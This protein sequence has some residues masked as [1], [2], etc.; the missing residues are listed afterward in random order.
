MTTES[1]SNIASRQSSHSNASTGEGAPIDPW[2]IWVTF[3]RCWV[4]AVPIGLVIGTIGAVMVLKSFQPEYTARYIVAAN[5][6]WVIYKG[7]NEAPR[8]LAASEKTWVIDHPGVIQAVMGDQTVCKAPSLADPTTRETN[9]RKNLSVAGAGTKD[10]MMIKY[11]DTDRDAAAAVCNAVVAEYLQRRAEFDGTQSRRLISVIEKQIDELD[12]EISAK[13]AEVR[14]YE[15]EA[16]GF[17]SNNQVSVIEDQSQTSRLRE[18]IDQRF[19]LEQQISLIEQDLESIEAGE[20]PLAVI[21]GDLLEEMDEQDFT[22]P[23]SMVKKRLVTRPVLDQAISQ[24]RKVVTQKGVVDR[25]QAALIAIKADRRFGP[26]YVGIQ[27]TEDLL[28]TAQTEL[29]RL[30][31]SVKDEVRQELEQQFEAQYQQDLEDEGKELER[32]EDAWAKNRDL[33]IKNA[34]KSSA[35]QREL[36]VKRLQ[37]DLGRRKRQ[38]EMVKNEYQIEG[39]KRS[40]RVNDSWDVDKH[41]NHLA[42]LR[43]RYAAAEQRLDA[44]KTESEN[45]SRVQPIAAATPPTK[46]NEEVPTKKLAMVALAGFCVPFG[47]GLL[48]ELHTKRIT[49]SHHIEALAVPPVIG[50][51]ARAPRAS[52]ARQSRGR[53]VFEESVDSLRANLALSQDTRTARSFCIASSMSGEGKSTAASQLA[54]SLAKSSGKTVLII[55][56]DLRCPD[57][58]D[59]FGLALEPGLSDVVEEKSTLDDAINRELGDLIHILPAG[60]LKASPHRIL[61]TEAVQGLIAR[62]MEEYEYVIFDSAPILA[63]GETLAI[64]AVVDS[65]L[66]CVMR[67]V[68][69]TDSVLRSTRRLE[70]AGANIVGTIFSGVTPS[71]YVY[72]YGDYKYSNL[73]S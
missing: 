46:P 62:C 6:D 31:D 61:T 49:D 70:A 33:Q 55:D 3:R 7:I 26:G 21:S 15:V 73:V 35:G 18:L 38:L 40:K 8:D 51:L 1:T 50:E 45:M 39:D 28:V 30:M 19:E 20:N 37:F 4:W 36:V 63:A 44:I 32:L 34:S 22:P 42:M 41:V 54:I 59:I 47:L 29:D 9:L 56:A 13:E 17:S 68:T 60:R 67:D 10:K 2:I 27:E 64:A 16:Q 53:R 14:Q 5:Q 65:T 66:M 71:K 58:H 48:W 57:Q 72:R 25:H 11:T 24:H 12:V 43:E 52:G 69:R 23:R